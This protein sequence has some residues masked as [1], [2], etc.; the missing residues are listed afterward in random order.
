MI[1]ISLN[2]LQFVINF[3]LIVLPITLFYSTVEVNDN[4]DVA[5][6]AISEKLSEVTILA[7]QLDT[8]LCGFKFAMESDNIKKLFESA[9]TYGQV[10]D[11]DHELRVRLF[12]Y[13]FATTKT[14]RAKYK[15]KF[16]IMPT[17]KFK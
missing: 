1:D 9:E 16:Y 5:I 4:N 15:Y 10:R 17:S 14:R 6:A 13:N 3:I 11:T 2:V 7:E 12:N 8:T